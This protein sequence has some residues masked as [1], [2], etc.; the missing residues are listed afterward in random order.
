MTALSE[1]DQML[2]AGAIYNT[3][4]NTSQEQFI[5]TTL[6]NAERL[7]KSKR[8]YNA[9]DVE[10][11]YRG[12]LNLIVYLNMGAQKKDP[13]MS[14]LPHDTLIVIKALVDELN[15]LKLSANY[16]QTEDILNAIKAASR[17]PLVIQLNLAPMMIH[18]F[19]RYLGGI[20]DSVVIPE[21]NSAAAKSLPIYQIAYPQILPMYRKNNDEWD[22]SNLARL[23]SYV[24]LAK[25][26]YVHHSRGIRFSLFH[27]HGKTGRIRAFDFEYKFLKIQNYDEAVSVLKAF[28][29]DKNNGNTHPHSFRT[30][31]LSTLIGIDGYPFSMVSREFDESLAELDRVLTIITPSNAPQPN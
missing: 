9:A 20:N 23:K 11:F 16:L 31:L 15:K 30:M 24:S 10:A 4:M 29:H 27:F 8:F 14:L 5:K 13:D 18:A 28:L 25:Q 7:F 19:Y 12:L 1:K 22:E 3:A 26:Q 21:V 17:F 2:L 6:T